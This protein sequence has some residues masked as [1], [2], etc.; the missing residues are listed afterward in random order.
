M[1]RR[2]SPTGLEQAELTQISMMNPNREEE[3]ILNDE[4]HKLL[5]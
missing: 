3:R 1:W 5:H 4:I 2:K